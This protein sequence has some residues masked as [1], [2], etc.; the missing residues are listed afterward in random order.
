MADCLRD[1]LAALGISC[2]E[3]NAGAAL[4][5][6][7]G[8]LFA[9]VPGTLEQPALLFCTHMD[10]VAPACGKRAVLH[11]DGRIT[12]AGDTVLG[13]DDLAGMAVLLEVLESLREQNIAHRP[14]ELLFTAAEEP[15]CAGVRHF[16][17]SQCAAKTGFV[18][19]L[20]GP[21]GTAAVAAPTILS[22]T[23][24]VTGRAAHAGFAPE[25]GVH[26]IDAAA[27]GLVRLRQGRLEGGTTLN[28]GLISGGAA[29]NIVPERCVLSGE[30]RSMRHDRALALYDA[31]CEVFREEAQAV[32]ACA[33]VDC[34]V[35]LRAYR[36][37]ENGDAVRRFQR[38]CA[39]E[40]LPVRLI[41]TFGGS[42][43]AALQAH[44]IDSIVAANAMFSCHS[45][46]EY[47]TVEDLKKTALLV[48]R[49]ITDEI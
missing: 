38:A 11:E 40:R 42:D 34:D 24:E 41:E 1:R 48:A 21:I 25:A 16:D 29:A 30:I 31:L 46:D 5:G 23:V 12:S 45:T 44:G 3:D 39:A 28:V 6:T 8:N 36:A 22:F 15:Y 14:L 13:A 2:K 27:R 7:A 20:T 4:G 17:F 10:T 35:P 19:D 37:A 32:G 49:L 43:N 18:L 26:A 33:R 47:T 9:R